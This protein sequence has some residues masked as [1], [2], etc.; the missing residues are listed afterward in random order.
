MHPLVR[1]AVAAA[2]LAALAALGKT[3]P[4][5]PPT[6]VQP[7]PGKG[8]PGVPA[9]CGPRTLPEGNA[10]IPLPRPGAPLDSAPA[11]EDLDDAPAR[12][13]PAKELIPRRPDRPAEAAAY[14]FPIGPAE[15]APTILAGLDVPSADGAPLPPSAVEIGADA[16]DEVIALSLEDQ[17]GPAEVAMVGELFGTTVVTAHLVH[18][19]G[20]LRQ[21]LLFHGGLERVGPRAVV[22]VP[23][24]PG[25][26]IGYAGDSQ[27]PGR[28]ALYLE[29]RQLREGVSLGALDPNRILEAA[30][31]IPLDPRN[32]LP[33]HAAGD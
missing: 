19:G 14:R 15:S 13:E 12:T 7:A 23:L 25:D 33:L 10:C 29:A 8:V 28:V 26:V 3:P 11:R 16:G 17:E 20:R 6:A 1:A 24:E 32:V 18:D 27:R 2:F 31:T 22:G 4:P 21:I 9:T 30:I 5:A